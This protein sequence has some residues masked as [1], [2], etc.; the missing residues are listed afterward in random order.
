MCGDTVVRASLR[1]LV[2]H[3]LRQVLIVATAAGC[4]RK[5]AVDNRVGRMRAAHV[6]TPHFT[7]LWRGGGCHSE[8]SMFNT[9]R[10]NLSSEKASSDTP[11]TG[12]IWLSSR[13]YTRLLPSASETVLHFSRISCIVSVSISSN[14]ESHISPCPRGLFSCRPEHG[15]GVTD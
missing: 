6:Y 8:C 11:E 9:L 10:W 3:Q 14:I 12:T 4:V 1:F 13:G 5:L 2:C 15:P 7:L